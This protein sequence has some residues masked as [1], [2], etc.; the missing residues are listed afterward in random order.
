LTDRP[1]D[2]RWPRA[3]AHGAIDFFPSHKLCEPA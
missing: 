2:R 3:A 1:S